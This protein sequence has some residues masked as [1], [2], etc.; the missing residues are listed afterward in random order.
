MP[1]DLY[2]YRHFG[3]VSRPSST[4]IRS[5]PPS[6]P[7]SQHLGF[8]K[9]PHPD[10][11]KPIHY[12]C[13]LCLL[14]WLSSFYYSLS[15]FTVLCPYIRWSAFL[16]LKNICDTLAL[17]S[18]GIQGFPFISWK[19]CW[20]SLWQSMMGVYSSTNCLSSSGQEAEKGRGGADAPIFPSRAQLQWQEDLR[21]ELH[22]SDA[23]SSYL[24]DWSRFN[25][26][27]QSL[28]TV[29][30]HYCHWLMAYSWAWRDWV[31]RSD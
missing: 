12:F 11:R 20:L 8:P 28:Y 2:M 16:Y 14:K 24:E 26:V 3:F 21:L 29:N 19:S 6:A 9:V 22:L 18:R 17:E 10:S 25:A 31:G 5:S 15:E 30:M 1:S 4:P 27:Q 23:Q 7:L 13:Q